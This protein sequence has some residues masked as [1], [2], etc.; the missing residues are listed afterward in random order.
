MPFTCP[1]CGYPDLEEEPHNAEG[2]GSHEICCSCDTHFGYDD[3]ISGD[4][5]RR[6]ER[7]RELRTAWIEKGMQWWSSGTARPLLWNPS[8]QLSDLEE[9]EKRAITKTEHQE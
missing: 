6:L 7:H 4:W 9:K 8:N 1:V 2:G 5:I 3:V